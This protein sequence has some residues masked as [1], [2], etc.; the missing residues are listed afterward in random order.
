MIEP[1]QDPQQRH[2]PAEENRPNAPSLEHSLGSR[3][4][5]RA[6]VFG[7]SSAEPLKELAAAADQAVAKAAKR[8]EP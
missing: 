6:E 1:G 3:E 2:E 5:V 4:M 7:E 8:K